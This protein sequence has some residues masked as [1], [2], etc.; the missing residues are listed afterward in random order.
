MILGLIKDYIAC[1]TYMC[2]L[3]KDNY[4][5]DETLLRSRRMNLIPKKGKLADGVYFNFH[6]GGCYF[7]FENGNI[8][9]DFGPNDRCDGF[10]Y[11][12]L[13][14]FLEQTKRDNYKALHDKE[15]FKK[16]F[17]K[18]ISIGQ[19]IKPEWQPNTHLFYLS[20]AS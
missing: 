3:L 2:K 4:T 6:G 1:A 18:L 10:D 9:I 19:I 11:Y 7:E 13:F 14:D 15:V 5:I 17:D 16:E 20:V 8:D 12:R